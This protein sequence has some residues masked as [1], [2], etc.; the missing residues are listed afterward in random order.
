MM[1]KLCAMIVFILSA[2]G[3]PAT[4]RADGPPLEPVPNV[5]PPPGDSPAVKE[6]AVGPA[7]VPLVA[8]KAAKKPLCPLL[9]HFLHP[10]SWGCGSDPYN[11]GCSSCEDECIFL[12]G[13]CRQFY[14]EPC[15]KKS[16]PPLGWYGVHP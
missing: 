8:E 5:I 16:P 9:A 1:T 2:L 4:V 11:P 3:M 6:A 14:G 10:H 12:F 15:Y 13:S 7:V